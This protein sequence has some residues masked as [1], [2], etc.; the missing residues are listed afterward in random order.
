MDNS[1]MGNNSGEN[2]IYR[3]ILKTATATA[4]AAVGKERNIRNNGL[5]R[6]EQN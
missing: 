4:A 3:Q 6:S 1:E 5:R 2:A